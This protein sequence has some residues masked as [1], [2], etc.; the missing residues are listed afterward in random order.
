MVNDT[1]ISSF[2]HYSYIPDQIP[3]KLTSFLS[4]VN[5]IQFKNIDEII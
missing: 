3:Q 5:F 4:E 1:Y 2:L